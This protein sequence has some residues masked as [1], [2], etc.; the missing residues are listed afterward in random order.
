MWRWY[1]HWELIVFIYCE[2]INIFNV[3]NNLSCKTFINKCQV[4]CQKNYIF[5]LNVNWTIGID[6]LLMSKSHINSWKYLRFNISDLN[7]NMTN[8]HL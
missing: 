3:G 2:K 6:I 5:F 1:S 4:S 8:T 7:S